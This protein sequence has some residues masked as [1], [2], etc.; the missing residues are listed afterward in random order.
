[1]ST[2]KQ[3][4]LTMR[5]AINDVELAMSCDAILRTPELFE[6]AS[7]EVLIKIPLGVLRQLA[8]AYPALNNIAND[9]AYNFQE[10][11]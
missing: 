10:F 8:R 4:A 1:M 2:I 11:K 3:R 9:P 6:T 5:N 7:D